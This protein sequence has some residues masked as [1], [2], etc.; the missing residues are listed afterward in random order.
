MTY[1]LLIVD[2][3]LANIRLLERLFRHDYNCLTASSGDEAIKLIEQHDVAIVIT[4]QRMPQITGIELLKQTAEL[5]PHMVRILLTGY[6]DVEVLVEAINSGLV[7]MYVT[8]PWNNDD[9]KQRVGRAVEHYEN[10]KKGHSLE[11]ANRR[12]VERIAEMRTGLVRALAS[13]VAGTDEYLYQHSLRVTRYASLIGERTDLAED[14]RTEL[15]AAA[16]LHEVGACGV[17]EAGGTKT[18]ASAAEDLAEGLGYGERGAHIVSLVPEL[19]DVA[20]IVR[21][22]EEKFDGSGSPRGLIGDQIPLSSRII[23]LAHE[24]DMITNPRNHAKAIGH[25]QAM[26]RLHE[27]AG[28]ELDPVVLQTLA[29]IAVSDLTD[30]NDS[31]ARISGFPFHAAIA[32]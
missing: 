30:P 27:R 3:E 11:I 21:F 12:L 25:T 7:Y 16:L 18:C 32:K 2:D 31:A 20:E 15:S 14:A 22:Q 13:T 26:A 4:D 1:K 9:L 17:R 23:R 5:R 29:Q 19:G 28:E 8:K 6:A 24:Y 10:R